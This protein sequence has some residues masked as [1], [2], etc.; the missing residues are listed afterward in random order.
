MI[1]FGDH[2]RVVATRPALDAL[3]RSIDEYIS[4]PQD[5]DE[6]AMRLLIASGELC[7]GLLDV[8]FEARGC[9]DWGELE[10]ACAALTVGAARVHRREGRDVEVEGPR[11]ALAR[12]ARLELPETV[13][14]RVPEGFAF[15]ALDPALYAAAAREFR[16]SP[17]GPPAV[18]GVR[19]IGVSLAAVV[20][21]HAGARD[22]PVTVRPVG[23][24]FR[25]AL[26]LGPTLGARLLAQPPET[27]FAVVDEGPGL[28]GSSFG[29]VADWLED[30]GI[31][32]DRIHFFPGHAG[33]VGPEASPRHRERWRRAARHVVDFESF[34]RDQSPGA[35]WFEDDPEARRCPVVDIASGRWRAKLDR[36]EEQWPPAHLLQE[37]RKYIYSLGDRTW[38]AKFAGFGRHGEAKLARARSLARAGWVP[39][40]RALRRGFLV[41]EWLSDAHPLT[42]DATDRAAL[43]DA[44][45]GYLA[46]RSRTFPA[47]DQT[48]G[49]APGQLF[50]MIEVNLCERFGSGATGA[51][52]PWRARLATIS[53]R[54]RRVITDNRLHAWEWLR[55]PDGR[56]LKADALDHAEAHDLIGAQDL[57]WDVAGACVELGL[58]DEERDRLESRLARESPY[59]PDPL[60]RGFHM[61]AYLAFQMGSY[62]MAARAHAFDP[63]EARRL[64]RAAGRYADRLRLFLDGAG[65]ED[66]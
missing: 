37:R 33:D 24:P 39:P 51:L 18:V 46:F 34:R 35:S 23:P 30:H 52:D 36:S 59:R 29:A 5:R 56:W 21:V 4:E 32:P 31:A 28:S 22:L 58:D 48:P 53:G 60:L 17:P 27:H 8:T 14:I 25:R 63:A 19:S 47:T 41:E 64:D 9:D 2:H 62:A 66:E 26:R 11:A 13:T 6:A 65:D 15:Y 7:Q 45:A 40:P 49:A 50:E 54:I 10:E 12:L 16:A 44:V 61:L 43:L 55:L 42:P 20:A 38:M 57:A 1:V 3:G